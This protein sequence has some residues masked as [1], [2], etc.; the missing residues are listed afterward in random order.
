MKVPACALLAALVVAGCGTSPPVLYFTLASGAPPRSTSAP[1]YTIAVGPVTVP[2][3]VDRPH[4][5]LRV[6]PTRVE[7]AEQARWAAPLKIEIPRVIA[8]QLARL[9]PGA[10]TVTSSERA[11][12]LPDYRVLVDI[13]RFDS[14]PGEAAT[15]EASWSVRSRDGAL[16]DGRSVANEQA[17]GGYDEVVAAHS[18]ALGGVAK[19]IA[20]AIV[21][22]RGK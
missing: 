1:I 6:S 8:N 11:T 17:G 4:L 12:G 19:D 2:E 13:Q 14:A 15:I 18:R 5:V 16:V 10:S 20:A 21:K 9:L 3:I 7:V 22:L